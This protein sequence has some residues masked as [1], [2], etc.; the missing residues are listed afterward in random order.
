[1]HA[2]PLVAGAE[3]P[4][5]P[6]GPCEPVDAMIVEVVS[7][8]YAWAGELAYALSLVGLPRVRIVPYYPTNSLSI[9]GPRASVEQLI[10]IIK[11]SERD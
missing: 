4:T 7:L 8:T 11:P 5:A 1:M 6:A 3:Q 10:N 9:T 2:M